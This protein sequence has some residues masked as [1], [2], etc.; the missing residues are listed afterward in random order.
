MDQGTTKYSMS[1]NMNLCLRT[2]TH[3]HSSEYIILFTWGNN[4]L[5]QKQLQL[6]I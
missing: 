3:M 6:H 1:Y 2:H 5:Y 4:S